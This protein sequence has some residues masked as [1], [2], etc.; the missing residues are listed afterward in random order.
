MIWLLTACLSSKKVTDLSVDLVGADT[1]AVCPGVPQ[2]IEVELT[3]ENGRTKHTR[4]SGRDHV[5]WRELKILFDGNPQDGTGF[6]LYADPRRSL[7][8]P[9]ELRV[10]LADRPEVAQT[11]SVVPRYDCAFTADFSGFQGA[12]GVGGASD[13]RDGRDGDEAERR[14]D[15]SWAGAGQ[16]GRSGTDGS[17]GATGGQGGPGGQAR[18]FVQRVE[19]GEQTLV[20]VLIEGEVLRDDAWQ[21]RTRRFLIDPDGGSLTVDV[22]GGAGGRGE[23]GGQGGEGGDGGDG[24]PPGGIGAGADGGRGGDGG[25]GGPGGNAE[26]YVDPMDV[27]L[28]DLFLVEHGGGQGGEAGQGG[29]G[30]TGN[31][32]GSPGTPGRTGRA[33]RDG[34]PPS[35]SEQPLKPYF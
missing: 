28:L 1:L 7:N 9:M 25:D 18:V 16:D 8:G 6:T 17:P 3:L 14:D 22:R 23:E 27:D 15:G 20:Q 2:A 24:D 19:V 32:G 30:G 26:F 11:L 31:P 35:T 21:A 29:P 13:G 4:G 33:G 12:W 5:A 34:P 10:E